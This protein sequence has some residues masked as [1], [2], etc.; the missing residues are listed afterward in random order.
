MRRLL[1]TLLI[2][3]ACVGELAATNSPQCVFQRYSTFEGL[4]HDHVSD[5]YTDSRGFVWVC[6]WYGVSRFDGYTFKNFSTSPGDYSPLAHHRFLSVNEDANGHLWFTTYNHHVYRLNRY[7]EQFEDVVASVPQADA[8]HGRVHFAQ[9]D[10]EGGTYL[11]LDDVGVV[12]LVGSDD[13]RP[14]RVDAIYDREMLGG[15]ASAAHVDRQGNVWIAT[16]Q[17]TLNYVPSDDRSCARI[18]SRLASPVFA[19]AETDRWVWGAASCGVV[20][21][22][23][24]DG[25]AVEMPG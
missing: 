2:L 5:I 3:C 21:A 7:T 25:H 8:K 12:R 20:K 19:F 17:G 4:T 22:S 1:L 15:E 11:A 23:K 18:V 6:T 24:T 16:A 9:H 10:A 14:V 13:E